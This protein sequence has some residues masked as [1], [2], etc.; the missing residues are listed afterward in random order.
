M[1]KLVC[2]VCKL[3]FTKASEVALG[4][5]VIECW[6]CVEEKY[7][8]A[9]QDVLIRKHLKYLEVEADEYYDY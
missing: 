4:R 5:D 1:G 6:S 8:D 7:S 9:V 2:A 3:Y